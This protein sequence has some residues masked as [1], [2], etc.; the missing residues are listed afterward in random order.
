MGTKKLKDFQDQLTHLLRDDAG[1]LKAEQKDRAIAQAIEDYAKDRPQRKKFD[2]N[3]D[4]ATYDIPAPA[5]WIAAATAGAFQSN[6]LSIEYPADEREP[7]LLDAEDWLIYSKVDG[8]QVIRLVSSTP[9]AGKKARVE[10]TTPH[11]QP[12]QAAATTAPDSDFFAICD[13]AA[14]HAFEMLAAK[15][16]QSIDPTI[17]ADSMD[18]QTQA[19]GYE[20]A[21]GRYAKRYHAA[22]RQGGAREVAAGGAVVDLDRDNQMG[23]DQMTHPRRSR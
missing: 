4:G 2:F 22:L 12:T 16:R 18:R 10:Y 19:E 3:G 17:S 9:Q 14:S 8:T 15:A 23:W 1:L 7:V 21:A 20:R 13:L 5:D 6:V 11:T